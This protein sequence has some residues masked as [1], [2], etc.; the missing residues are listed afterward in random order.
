MS[1][2]SAAG[3]FS[4]INSPRLHPNSPVQPDGFAVEIAVADYFKCETGI[5]FRTAQPLWEWDHRAQRLEHLRRRARK[6]GCIVMTRI[7]SRARSRAMVS[8]IPTMAAF[9]AE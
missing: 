7:P 5:F 3:D 9:A 8:V 2:K 6:P 1:A 4:P